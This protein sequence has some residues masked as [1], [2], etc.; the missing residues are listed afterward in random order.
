MKPIYNKSCDL[1]DLVISNV[2]ELVS[3]ITALP[4]VSDHCPILLTVTTQ[5]LTDDNAP[6]DMLVPDFTHT[7]FDALREH[8]W[9]QPLMESIEGSTC[10]ESAWFTWYTPVCSALCTYS[11][12]RF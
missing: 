12:A 11:K 9:N 7:N 6:S 10:I 8:L 2:G 5:L 1:L 4:P 3:D